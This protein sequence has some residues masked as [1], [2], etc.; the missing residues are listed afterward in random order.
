MPI[1]DSQTTKP[2]IAAII[3][4]SGYANAK[5]FAN[6]CEFELADTSKEEEL[7]DIRVGPVLS[8]LC[9]VYRFVV[10]GHGGDGAEIK[11]LID[12]ICKACN[13]KLS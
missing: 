4:P 13:V 3:I 9:E 1:S 11:V 7:R 8:Q 12:Q 6:D 5:E 2:R 10:H